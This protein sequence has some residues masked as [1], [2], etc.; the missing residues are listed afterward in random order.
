VVVE[1]SAAQFV[2]G[3]IIARQGDLLRVQGAGDGPSIA[4]RVAE[5]YRLSGGEHELRPGDLGICGLTRE[6][7]VGCR[8]ESV[9]GTQYA[10]TE[11]DGESHRLAR[12]NV[13]LPN[14]LTALNLQRHFARAAAR[15]RFVREA[16]QA[17]VPRAPADWRPRPH[18][19]LLAARAGQWYSARLRELG[20]ERVYV[21]W[22]ADERVTELGRAELLPEPPYVFTPHRGNY[23]L[24]RPSSPADPW[25]TVRVEAVLSAERLLVAN[26]N[27]E[28]R[29]VALEDVVPLG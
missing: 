9:S 29:D 5:I 10:V 2:A 20:R 8:V 25:E 7:W 3:R 11:A 21:I 23:V 1:K 14:E 6:R 17:G 4:A 19:R 15:N 27:E 12:V 26:V 18:E 28:R 16:R 13:L 22:Q 24:A